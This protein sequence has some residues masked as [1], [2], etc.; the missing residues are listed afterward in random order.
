MS[1]KVVAGLVVLLL[2][3]WMSRGA[4]DREKVTEGTYSGPTKPE[5]PKPLAHCVGRPLVLKK[6]PPVAYRAGTG[7]LLSHGGE[8]YLSVAYH[9]LLRGWILLKQRAIREQIDFVRLMRGKKKLAQSVGAVSMP[10]LGMTDFDAKDARGDLVLFRIKDTP[11]ESCYQLASSAPKKK[12]PVWV[13]TVSRGGEKEIRMS[14]GTIVYA[15]DRIFSIKITGP[16]PHRPYSGA[17]VVNAENKVVGAT[18]G[19]GPG[20]LYAAPYQSYAK[21]LP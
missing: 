4:C 13:V 19:Y 17:P 18:I 6:E 12:T 1:G 16:S 11:V 21:A 20:V 7:F 10:R 9:I 15:S 3:V 14:P 8:T 2:I 5:A